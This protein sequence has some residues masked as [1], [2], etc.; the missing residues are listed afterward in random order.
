MEDITPILEPLVYATDLLDKESQPTGSEVYILLHKLMTTGLKILDGDS[1][2]VKDMKKR[3]TDGLKRRFKVDSDGKPNEEVVTSP[4]MLS[5]ILDPRYKCLIAREI[6]TQDKV[7]LLHGT[8]LKLLNETEAPISKESASN[9]QIKQE[10]TDECSTLGKKKK[11]SV[12]L[13]ERGC[14]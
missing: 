7:S 14:H 3:I 2:T 13:F 1:G 12:G 11:K 8:I 4:L 9:V 6:L 10:I 5:T